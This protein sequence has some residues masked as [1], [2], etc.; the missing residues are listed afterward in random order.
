MKCMGDAWRA[1]H[2][3]VWLVMSKKEKRLSIEEIVGLR[4][5]RYGVIFTMFVMRS[6]IVMSGRSR[7]GVS[8][9]VIED[10]GGGGVF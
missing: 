8:K 3:F 9:V 5:T 4:K 7:G 6:S 10:A 1:K 2:G